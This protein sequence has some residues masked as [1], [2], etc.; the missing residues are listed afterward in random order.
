MERTVTVKGTGSLKLKPDLTVIRFELVTV[1]KSYD[2]AMRDSSDKLDELR[3]TLRGI[4]FS[5]DDL[6][7]A[8]FNVRTKSRSRRDKN[9]DYVS[10]FEGYCCVHSLKLSFDF[11]SERLAR[12]LSA[13][14]G[15][16]AEPD[17][18]IGFTVKDKNAV[19]EALLESAARN[20]RKKAEILTKASGVELGEL[21]TI[22]YNCEE[23]EFTSPTIYENAVCADKCAFAD[24]EPDDIDV[25][26]TATFVWSII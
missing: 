14:T 7:T 26:D 3:Q 24:I 21:I 4:G 11:D 22:S 6:M 1:D 10:V 15:C 9:G 20:A 2:K 16:I 18:N 12:V 19:N 13:I 25:S 8:G 5:K 23:F 17:L